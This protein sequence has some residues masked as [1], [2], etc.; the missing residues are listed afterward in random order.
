MGLK[1]QKKFEKKLT[2]RIKTGNKTQVKRGQIINSENTIHENS[3]K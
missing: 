3:K 2:K 1:I